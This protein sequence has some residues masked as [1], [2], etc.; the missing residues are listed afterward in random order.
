MQTS[1]RKSGDLLETISAFCRDASIA[2]STFGR[3]A[4]NDGKFVSRLRNGSRVTPETWERVS[5]FIV[6]Q[7]G[8]VPARINPENLHLLSPHRQSPKLKSPPK[9]SEGQGSSEKNFRFFDNRQKYLLF[10]NTCS[11]KETIAH[12]AGM[13]LRNIHPVPPAVRLF[14]AGMG[15]G[16][17]LTRLV[18][19][20][21][22]RLP[23]MPFY[24]S[25]KEIS[26]EDVRLSLG[27]MPDRFYEHPA[28]VLIVTNMYYS[29]APW[30]TPKEI[31]AA[32]SMVWKEVP[33]KGTTAFEFDEQIKGL[34]GF[35]AKHWQ[36]YHSPKSGNPIY[37]RPVVLVLY[38]ED[39]KFLL[40]DVIPKRG[41]AH[42]DYDLILASQPYRSR[43]S[44]KFKAEK[45][46]APLTR[47]LGKGGRLLGV[48]SYGHDPGLEIIQSIWPGEN[49]FPNGRHDIL[50]AVKAELGPEAADYNFNANS[51]ARAIFRYEMHAL[52]TEISSSIGTSTLF[53]AWNAAVYVAQIEDQ[54]LTQTLRD[55]SYLEATNKVLQKY[56]GLW[57]NDESYTIS[58]KRDI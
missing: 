56:G 35:L 47:A 11:E 21:H 4:V 5:E 12:R 25:S 43:V 58:R 40:N 52:P 18:R 48:H 20:M 46:I 22:Q 19:E 41:M 50:R 37:E 32:T 55:Q 27:K 28:S 3:L 57:F 53:A 9:T 26:L 15:D 36:A 49:P 33:L 14:D 31:S 44:A 8:K 45:V 38:R 6:S 7:G 42:A 30:L 51:D 10:V 17:V 54:R 2:E 29:E 23:T 24:I 39:H 13:E 34:D 16:S 1:P